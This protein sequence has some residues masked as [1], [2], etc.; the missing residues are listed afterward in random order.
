MSCPSR[1][2]PMTLIRGARAGLAAAA[3]PPHGA[4]RAPRPRRPLAPRHGGGGASPRAPHFPARAPPPGLAVTA[5]GAAMAGLAPRLLLLLCAAAGPALGWDRSGETCGDQAVGGSSRPGTPQC[6]RFSGGR[7]EGG[8]A[9]RFWAPSKPACVGVIPHRGQRWQPRAAS[10]GNG[11]LC[12]VSLWASGVS[13][14]F[15]S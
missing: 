6:C 15:V 7:H 2:G 4:R 8:R 10:G 3:P 9:C 11:E 13:Q 1:D 12:R 14:S 5:P